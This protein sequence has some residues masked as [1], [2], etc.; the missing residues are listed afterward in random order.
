MLLRVTQ[1]FV[2]VCVLAIAFPSIGITTTVSA[3]NL[4][5]GDQL[6][7]GQCAY[8]D[9]GL[10]HLCYELVLSSVHLL[11]WSA[12]VCTSSDW[13]STI[14]GG[15]ASAC[16][17]Y[18]GQHVNQVGNPGPDGVAIMQG[19]GN[20]V[21]YDSTGNPKWSTHTCC[22]GSGTSLSLQNDGNL[23]VYNNGLPLWSLPRS[24]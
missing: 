14:D 4:Y 21:L 5:P 17:D 7:N 19:D 23:V 18:Y 9:S 3:I 20:F 15:I 10:Y 13:R 2:L 11:R 12:P 8:S 22:W 1:G 16:T 6:T 24:G